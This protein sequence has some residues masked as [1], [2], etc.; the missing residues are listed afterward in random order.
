MNNV[1]KITG[2]ILT[3]IIIVFTIIAILGIWGA[4][5]LEEI[6]TKV[7]SSLLVVFVASAVVL[8][9]TTVLIRDDSSNKPIE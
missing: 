9:I 4:I 5:D 1:R 2:Y 7:L 3:G 6:M 8:F